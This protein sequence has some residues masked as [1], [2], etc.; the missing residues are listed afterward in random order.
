M[1][2]KDESNSSEEVS[3]QHT[4]PLTKDLGESAA[5]IASS[6]RLHFIMHTRPN[7]P[8]FQIAVVVL[9]S[10]LPFPAIWLGMYVLKNVYWTFLLYHGFCLV[11]VIVWGKSLWRDSLSFPT[12]KQSVVL[13][14]SSSVFVALALL[15]Y[16]HF[17]NHILSSDRTF[18]LLIEQGYHQGIWL[19]MTVYFVCV[20][21]ILEELY[22]RG[23][24]L[25]RLNQLQQEQTEFGVIWSSI[26]YAAFHY[27]ILRLV[28]FPGWAEIGV[29]LLAFYGALMASIYRR[30]NSL[31]I[32]ALSHAFLTDLTAMVLLAALLARVHQSIL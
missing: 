3:K 19:P 9:L 25:N 16:Q 13:F 4:R 11:P 17:G 15:L 8:S 7:K 26:S 24:I 32:T 5:R 6:Q 23:V 30:T 1:T 18:A 21:P 27:L 31:I 29:L 22:W 14:F 20:N 12:G 10:L 28:L 2:I